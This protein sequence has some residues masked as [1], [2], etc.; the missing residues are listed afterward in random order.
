MN[1]QLIS[2]AQNQGSKSYFSTFIRLLKGLRM[3]L[4]IDCLCQPHDSS[5]HESVISA[6]PSS[7]QSFPPCCGAGLV[8]VLVLV[9]TPPPHVALHSDS[10]HSVYL[11]SIAKPLKKIMFFNLKENQFRLDTIPASQPQQTLEEKRLSSVGSAAKLDYRDRV[12]GAKRELANDKE[13]ETDNKLE[14]N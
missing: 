6:G 10:F 1:F 13:L 3:W 12:L 11:P 14:N 2:I 8:Q 9:I 4:K 5:L 7:L